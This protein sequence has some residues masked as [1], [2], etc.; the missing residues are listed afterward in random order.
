MRRSR[1]WD[2]FAHG[3]SFLHS[4]AKRLIAETLIGTTIPPTGS[5]RHKE[6]RM[7]AP[8]QL[9]NAPKEYREAFER[10][11]DEYAGEYGPTPHGFAWRNGV[12]WALIEDSAARRPS[13]EIPFVVAKLGSTIGRVGP[14]YERRFMQRVAAGEPQYAPTNAQHEAWIA[15]AG[16]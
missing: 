2:T 10:L 6:D 16:R 15:W 8:A 3:E 9:D 4:E 11:P 7:K 1:V 14:Y 12:D 13:W 5:R